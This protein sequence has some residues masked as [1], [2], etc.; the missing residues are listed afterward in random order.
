MDRSGVISG[1]LIGFRIARLTLLAGL[2]K[3]PGFLIPIVIAAFFGAGHQTDAYFLAYG[4]LLL[5]GGTVGQPLEVAIVPFAAHALSLGQRAAKVFMGSLFRRGLTLGL[6]AAFAGVVLLW[7]ALLLLRPEQIAIKDVLVFYML[8]APAAAAWCVAGLYTGSL[9]SAWHLEAG[10][11]GYGFRGAGALLGALFGAVVQELW[12]VAV[13]ASAGEWGRVWWLRTRWRRAVNGMTPGVDGAPARG[14]L[15]AAASQISANGLLSSAQ[16]IERFLVGTVAVAAISRIEYANRLVMVAAVL[17]DGGIGPWLLARWAT[18]RVRAG[19]KSDWLSVYRPLVL[20]GTA[21]LA[22]AGILALGAPLIVA[23]VLHHGAFTTD[24]AAVVTK[25]LRWYAIGYFFNM[26]ALCVERLLL[27][28]AQNRLFLVLTA[29]RS[30]VR[31]AT[32]MLLLGQIG[33]LALPAGYAAAEATY[34]VAL[35]VASRREG[36]PVA[37]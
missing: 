27:A 12:P 2:A 24:D 8:L 23:G 25:V 33:I 9:V 31:V 18:V 26:S 16:F 36:V 19:L 30:V 13:G 22:V 20:A 14:F 28:R 1:R 34:L 21:A 37:A 4:G 10:A 15:S 35:L 6:A 29:V 11:V 32:I 17:F 7:S 3:A 5:V